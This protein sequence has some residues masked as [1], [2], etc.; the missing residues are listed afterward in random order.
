VCVGVCVCDLYGKWS[1]LYVQG[2]T[3]RF[4]KMQCNVANAKLHRKIRRLN[5]PRGR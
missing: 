2:Q 1:L 4:Q 5:E 3:Q